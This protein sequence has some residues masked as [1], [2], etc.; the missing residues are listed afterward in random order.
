MH[1]LLPVSVC[2][3]DFVSLCLEL[4]CKMLIKSASLGFLQSYH[5]SVNCG[6]VCSYVLKTRFDLQLILGRK[7]ESF[8]DA[9]RVLVR[10]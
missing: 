5:I 2:A 10:V 6:E 3:E 7:E 8:K 1:A 9:C 4:G